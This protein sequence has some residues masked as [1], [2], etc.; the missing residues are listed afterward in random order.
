MKHPIKETIQI[1]EGITCN[2]TD[3]TLSCKKD[4]QELKRKIHVPEVEI[5]VE[6]NQISLTCKKGNKNHHKK[7]KTNITHISNIFKGLNEKFV[8]HLETVNVHFPISVKIEN[9]KVLISN[10]YG[11]KVPRYA[12]I[13][14]G[15]EVE[16]KGQKITVS[17][18]NKE[19]AGQTSANLEKATKVRGKDRRIY[20]DGIFITKKP[21]AKK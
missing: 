12:K 9:D 19:S 10:F 2:Y 11:E 8:Y 20:Q 16:V 7:I 21:G 5:K 6:S 14:S 15:T 3:E 4:S 13:V 1:P 18:I 17:S